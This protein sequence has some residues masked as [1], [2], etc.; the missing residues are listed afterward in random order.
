MGCVLGS[1]EIQRF[2]SET[3]LIGARQ[4]TVFEEDQTGMHRRDPRELR[5]VVDV[6]RDEGAILL[7]STREDIDVSRLQQPA[8]AND[9]EALTGQRQRDR[10]R[11]VLIEE[12]LLAD[13]RGRPI[14]G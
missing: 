4:A 3:K 2:A 14:R 6:R 1:D 9:V 5:E 7:Q 12:E 13:S 11:E 10:R 8:I